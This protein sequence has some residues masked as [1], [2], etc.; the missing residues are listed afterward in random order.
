MTL[1]ESVRQHR[2]QSRLGQYRKTRESLRTTINVT[3][4]QKSAFFPYLDV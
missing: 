1:F 2:M 4:D 3:S